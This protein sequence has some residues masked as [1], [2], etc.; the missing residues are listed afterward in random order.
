MIWWWFSSSNRSGDYNMAAQSLVRVRWRFLLNISFHIF[1]S[2][3]FYSV[4]HWKLY[5]IYAYWIFIS[6]SILVTSSSLSPSHSLIQREPV[7]AVSLSRSQAILGDY[8]HCRPNVSPV[9]RNGLGDVGASLWV[10]DCLRKW[11][12]NRHPSKT[13]SLHTKLRSWGRSGLFVLSWW[14]LP[15]WDSDKRFN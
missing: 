6:F 12:T 1:P 15:T 13:H 4:L 11:P 5:N 10:S 9:I 14:K 8:S 7:S 2:P 3:I